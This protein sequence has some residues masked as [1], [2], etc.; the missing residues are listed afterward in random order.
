VQ[1]VKD[2]VKNTPGLSF[3]DDEDESEEDI[4]VVETFYYWDCLQSIF[5]LYKILKNYSK[6]IFVQASGYSI[7]AGY[8]INETVLI[9]LIEANNLNMVDT[10]QSIPYLHSEYCSVLIEASNKNG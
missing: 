4:P 7:I 2:V 8:D 10:L 9:K 5:D 6:S 3:I 1:S